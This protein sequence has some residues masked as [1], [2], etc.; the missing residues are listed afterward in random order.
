M[1]VEYTIPGWAPAV[2]A[3]AEAPDGGFEARLRAAATAIPPSTREILG[4]DRPSP[5]DLA[6]APPP[7]PAT[8]AYCGPD[9]ERRLWHTLLHR[10]HGPSRLLALLAGMQHAEDVIS[11]RALVDSRG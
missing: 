9:E 4:L 1:K 8:L 5:S 10:H 2:P 6:L 3:R 7:R 11:A